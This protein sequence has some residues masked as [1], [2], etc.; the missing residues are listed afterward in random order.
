MLKFILLFFLIISSII[1]F[2]DELELLNGDK[3]T[4]KIIYMDEE[5]VKIETEYGIL[6]V[7]RNYIKSGTFS[8]GDSLQTGSTGLTDS[9]LLFEF[10]FNNNF[11]DTSGNNLEL[12]NTGVVLLNGIEQINNTGIYSVGTGQY[13]TVT[14]TEKINTLNEFSLS[15]WVSFQKEDKVQ[16]IISK[17]NTTTGEQAKGKFALSYYQGSIYF[18]IVDSDGYYHMLVTGNAVSINQWHHIV[19]LCQPGKLTLYVNNSMVAEES[20]SFKELLQDN[21]PIYFLT[22]KTGSQFSWSQYNVT[23]FMDNIRLY[24]RILSAGEI[25]QLFKEYPE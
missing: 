12:Q 15:L 19:A 10:L 21:S 5:I 22:A 6:D 16:Y 17:W 1:S 20:Y 14:S 11:N 8:S 24:D 18:Y 13:L 2:S 25:E 7:D 9:G 23:G 3:I 4:G